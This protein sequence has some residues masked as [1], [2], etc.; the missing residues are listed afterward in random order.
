MD[1]AQLEQAD[2][3]DASFS[4][5]ILNGA[6]LAGADLD[7]ADLR[8]VLGL[9]AEQICLAKSHAGAQMDSRLQSQTDARCG[10]AP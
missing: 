5:A 8:G 3:R 9:T 7:G 10:E 1:G 6:Q 2:L 4:G